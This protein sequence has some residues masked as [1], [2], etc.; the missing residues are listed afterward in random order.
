M[1]DWWRNPDEAG[2]WP[3]PHQ[4]RV[5][6]WFQLD[7]QTRSNFFTHPIMYSIADPHQQYWVT[8]LMPV[9]GDISLRGYDGVR[10]L[11]GTSVIFIT[12]DDNTTGITDD[13]GAGITANAFGLEPSGLALPLAFDTPQPTGSG[14]LSNSNFTLTAT[15]GFTNAPVNSGRSSGKY[16]VEFK[17]NLNSVPGVENDAVGLSSSSNVSFGLGN[18]TSIGWYDDGK[19]FPGDLAIGSPFTTGD[20]VGLAIDIDNRKVWQ[21]TNSGAWS[22]GGDP[23]ANTNGVALPG[24]DGVVFAIS[25][26]HLNDAMT[27]NISGP[28][29]FSPPIGFGVW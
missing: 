23:V 29:V 7:F 27:V 21:R 8:G 18:S 19:L 5:G 25:L 3:Q 17:S 12:D 22:N 24:T 9:G 10:S 6:N 2:N 4:N 14:T 20:V 1:T 15:S 28:F 11:D 26:A 13:F 16:Y